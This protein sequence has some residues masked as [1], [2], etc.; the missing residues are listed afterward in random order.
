MKCYFVRTSVDDNEK[1]R[2]RTI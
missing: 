1:L 2:A